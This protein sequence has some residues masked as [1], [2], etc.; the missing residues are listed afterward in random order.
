MQNTGI[1]RLD[2]LD[3]IEYVTKQ[4]EILIRSSFKLVLD[5]CKK[6]EM[7]LENY[8]YCISATEL[9]DAV[10]VKIINKL[11]LAAE[12]GWQK[13]VTTAN[14]DHATETLAST[15]HRYINCEI[16]TLDQMDTIDDIYNALFKIDN[17]SIEFISSY[18]ANTSLAVK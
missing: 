3:D 17:D 18:V 14:K 11:V 6:S 8:S 15:L 12:I 5:L 4:L 16:K 9:C 2:N 10:S 1:N 13:L 7:T